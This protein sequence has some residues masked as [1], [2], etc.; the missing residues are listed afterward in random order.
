MTRE[1]TTNPD[2]TEDD[3]PPTDPDDADICPD[4]GETLTNGTCPE[5]G[6]AV[7]E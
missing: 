7:D 2:D 3:T 1:F 6:W 4:C 5:C